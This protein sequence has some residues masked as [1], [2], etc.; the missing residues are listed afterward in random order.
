MAWG[1]QG[2]RGSNNNKTSGPVLALSPTAQIPA[3]AVLLAIAVSDNITNASATEDH[4]VADF[5]GN[6]WEKIGERTNAAAAGAGITLSLWVCRITNA[7]QTTDS[8]VLGLRAAATAKALGLYEYSLPAGFG[9]ALAGVASSEQDATAAPTVTLNSMEGGKQRAFL[10][11]VAR[12]EDN[13]GTYAMDADY[14]DRTKFGTTGGTGNTN[15]SAIVGDRVAS[16]NGDTFSVTGMS[17]SADCVTALVSLTE[18]PGVE[19]TV[20]SASNDGTYLNATYS[21]NG[22]TG[23]HGIRWP[24]SQLDDFEIKA[25]E[26]EDFM[27]RALLTTA[28]RRNL[29]AAQMVGK[30]AVVS[31]GATRNLLTVEG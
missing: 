16:I 27:L 30:S 9:F 24:L 20:Q 26:L 7:L 21:K 18:V 25:P 29:S 19:L 6:R 10:G 1:F 15:V 13:A 4:V 5:K 12:E 3:G 14:N 28:R 31:A 17:S 23:G 8:V 22:D 2:F 11:V